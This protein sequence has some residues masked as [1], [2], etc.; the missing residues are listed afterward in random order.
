MTYSDSIG[1]IAALLT[2]FSFMP[3]AYK[4]Y[5]TQKTTDLSLGMFSLFTLGVL[6]WTIYGIL[7]AAF[8]IILANIITFILAF[9][10]L[11][12]KIRYG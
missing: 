3:Q 1:F 8:P 9:Y 2:T 11:I 5:K 12:M 10:I 6:L 7:L 4:V